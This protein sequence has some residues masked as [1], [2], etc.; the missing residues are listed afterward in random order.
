MVVNCVCPHLLAAFLSVILIAA[1]IIP[2]TI[3]VA[4]TPKTVPPTKPP[5]AVVVTDWS[6]LGSGS[7][8][9]VFSSVTE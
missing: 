2:A 4:R 5:M 6:H 1:I 9:G 8:N 3:N 7:T